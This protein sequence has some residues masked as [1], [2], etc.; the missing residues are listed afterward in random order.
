MA[1]PGSRPVFSKIRQESNYRNTATFDLQFQYQGQLEV[2]NNS[3]TTAADSTP[4]G[5]WPAS[6]ETM[7]ARYG[8]SL[9]NRES[10]G[11]LALSAQNL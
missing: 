11:P 9:R 4:F 3:L 8:F 2:I 7:M 10:A 5:S 6:I 1:K